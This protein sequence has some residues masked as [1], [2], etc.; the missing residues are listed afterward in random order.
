MLAGA[1][2]VEISL[3][4]SGSAHMSSWFITC[5]KN[6]ILS[7]KNFHFTSFSFMLYFLNHSV[8]CLMCSKC[9]FSVYDV[10]RMLS[11][12]FHAK[13]SNPLS[14]TCITFE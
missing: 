8:T 4:F 10:M 12:L 1:L 6:C 2:I 5:P 11:M 14:V 3:V 9:S 13:C 7:L